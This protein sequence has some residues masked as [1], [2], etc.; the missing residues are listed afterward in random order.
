MKSSVFW[1]WASGSASASGSMSLRHEHGMDHGSRGWCC[2]KIIQLPSPMT[3]S[4][5]SY[6]F[7]SSPTL[8]LGLGCGYA[9]A[10]LQDC[11]K[12]A[13]HPWLTTEV[14]DVVGNDQL[15]LSITNTKYQSRFLASITYTRKYCFYICLK[16]ELTKNVCALTMLKLL[17][18]L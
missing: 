1:D 8:A 9:M 18:F 14:H 12:P 4:R 17:C 10:G 16:S 6:W 13:W 2:N 3:Y 11:Q 7:M 15:L 5:Y